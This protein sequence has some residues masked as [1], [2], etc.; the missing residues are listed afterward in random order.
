[1]NYG[2]WLGILAGN[3]GS[4]TLILFPVGRHRGANLLIGRDKLSLVVTNNI[5]PIDDQI[6]N[7]MSAST[8][9]VFTMCYGI[10][11]HLQPWY[12]TFSNIHKE[13]QTQLTL[14]ASFV[15]PRCYSKQRVY[16][17][18]ACRTIQSAIG[19]PLIDPTPINYPFRKSVLPQRP[20]RH[21]GITTSYPLFPTLGTWR[22]R[23]EGVVIIHQITLYVFSEDGRS[24]T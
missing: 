20:W 3:L 19:I 22:E 1:M 10:V 14:K 7:W 6:V 15:I 13:A 17:H 8:E 23:G 4:T 2:T 21:I 5:W 12:N 11:P 16:F 24:S 18:E 9:K